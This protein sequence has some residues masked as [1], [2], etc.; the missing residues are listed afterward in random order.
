VLTPGTAK[1]QFIRK[2]LGRLGS[3]VVPVYELH[4]SIRG[5]GDYAAVV[6]V[7]GYTK[8]LGIAA[9]EKE[10]TEIAATFDAFP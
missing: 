7:Q 6:P 8:E 4:F 9:V 5:E 1:L 10:A 3:E 2:T